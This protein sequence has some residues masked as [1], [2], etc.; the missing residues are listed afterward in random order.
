MTIPYIKHG[1]SGPSLHFLHANGYPPGCYE[2]FFEL[3]RSDYRVSGMLLRPLWPGSDPGEL[4]DWNPLSSDLLRF[5]EQQGG[6]PVIGVGHS[7]G[8]VVTLRAALWKPAPFRALIL[9]DPVLLMPHMILLWNLI[10]RLG[11]GERWHPRIAGALMR[12]R[13]FNNLETVFQGYRKREVFRY[14]SDEHLRAYIQGITKTR[15][16]G[17]FEL[18]YSPE[19]EAHIYYTGSWRDMGLWQNL[20]RLNV[21]TLIVRGAETDTFSAAAAALVK[22]KQPRVRVET[23]AESTH[24]LPLERPAQVFDI[25]QSFLKEVL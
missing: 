22:R 14:F 8:A 24:L 21:P 16:A 4:Q 17:G 3:L 7:I 5:L 10:R 15:P 13:T 18:A 23:L 25:M 1:G 11:Q 9:F 2:P 19:W 6:E 12:R 20:P